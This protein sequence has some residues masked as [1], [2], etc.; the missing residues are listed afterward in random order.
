MILVLSLFLG[1]NIKHLPHAR[2]ECDA[3]VEYSRN[4]T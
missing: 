2:G 1:F 3:L 4:L